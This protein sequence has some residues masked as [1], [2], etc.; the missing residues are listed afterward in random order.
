MIPR[1]WIWILLLPLVGVLAFFLFW[2]LTLV[3]WESLFLEGKLS[4]SNYVSMFVS[5]RIANRSRRPRTVRRT[6]LLG[7]FIGLR[8]PRHA[9]RGPKINAILTLASFPLDLSGLVVASPF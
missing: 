8:S 6:T 7:L 5:K 4:L 1:G 2:P 3:V 9:P